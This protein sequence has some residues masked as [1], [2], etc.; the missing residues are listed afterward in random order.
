MRSI[1][2][3]FSVFAFN[4]F[5]SQNTETIK[6]PKG[7]VYHYADNKIVENAKKLITENLKTD[8][9][10]LL[11]SNLMIG[12]ELWKRFK[13]IQ[14]LNVIKEGKVI[15][16]SDNV[17]LDGKMSQDLNDSKKIW[18]ELKKEVN[19]DFII[20]KADENELKY[21]WSVISF[22]IDEPL[23]IVETKTHKYILNLL[24]D[25]LKLMW[26]DEVPVVKNYYN[27]IEDTT[28]KS[29]N[30]FKSYKNGNEINENSKGNKETTLEKIVLL[31]SDQEFKERISTED[32]SII[33]N[34]TNTIFDE[35]FKNSDKPGKIMIQFELKKKKNEI[36]Y[37]VKDDIDLEIMK[38]FEK[39]VNKENYPNTK[40]DS[41]KIQLV[42]KVNSFNDTE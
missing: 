2:F 28:Y 18:D 32:I 14:K 12:P 19:N 34:K 10:S 27:P 31:N 9:Y 41:I 37:A 24:K 3:L 21:Y 33:I 26:L 39:R 23:L 15:I 17:E 29:E 1:I 30:G 11:Q 36:Q 35:F 38:E 6:I 25:N 8:N 13:N 4:S 20:R 5:K 22:D 16:H 40:K 7:I 42:Y